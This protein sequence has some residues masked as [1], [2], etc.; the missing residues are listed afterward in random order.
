MLLAM[1]TLF[2]RF[3]RRD[4]FDSFRNDSPRLS[5]RFWSFFALFFLLLGLGAELRFLKADTGLPLPF[6]LFRELPVFSSLRVAN[7]FLVPAMLG[8]SI[9]EPIE[10]G[11]RMSL[12]AP[13]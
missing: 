3:K 11:P 5:L 2:F 13:P 9:L 7:R 10:Q 12:L 1:S 4:S 6:A 8:I